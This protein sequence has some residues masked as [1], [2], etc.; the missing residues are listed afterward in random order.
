MDIEEDVDVM[1]AQIIKR[2]RKWVE[3]IAK[4]S[5]S[6]NMTT[7][8]SPIAATPSASQSVIPSVIPETTQGPAQPLGGGDQPLDKNIP[9][10]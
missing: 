5:Q 2:T 8:P 6:N 9:I 10:N 3:W 7:Q 1:M 4:R